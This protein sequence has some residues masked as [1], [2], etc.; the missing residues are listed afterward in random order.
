VGEGRF[1]YA[2]TSRIVVLRLSG[3]GTASTF[4]PATRPRS[5]LLTRYQVMWLE[6]DGRVLRSDRFTNEGPRIAR[7]AARRLPPATQSIALDGDK[8]SFRLGPDGLKQIL[9]LLAFR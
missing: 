9:P 7:V 1:A 8:V 2:T 3:H 6:R 5:L 4:R